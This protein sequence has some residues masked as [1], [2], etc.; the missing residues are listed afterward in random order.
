MKLLVL[1]C[2]S[3]FIAAII[4]FAT[5][6]AHSV[7]IH[8]YYGSSLLPLSLLLVMV[9]IGG[10]V[11]TL[12]GSVPVILGLM[13]DNGVLKKQLKVNIEEITNLRRLPL[14]DGN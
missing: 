12:L 14:K 1:I 2:I 10:V 9:F 6:N 4:V 11:L 13:R 5:F 3:L 8:Y 7:N